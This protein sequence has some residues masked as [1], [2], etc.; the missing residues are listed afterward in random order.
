[1]QSY[2]VEYLLSSFCN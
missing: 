1:M 2:V